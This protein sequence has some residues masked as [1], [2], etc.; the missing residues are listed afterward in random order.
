VFSALN[1]EL[2]HGV[3]LIL[4]ALLILQQVRF[5][6]ARHSAKKREELFQIITENADDM[7]ALVDMK[8]KRHY[9]S[10]SYKRILGYSPSELAETTSFEQIH[11]DDRLKVLDA[12]REARETGVGRR[13]Q[14]RMRHKNGTWRILESTASPIKSRTGEVEKLVIVNRDITDRKLA[15]ERLEHN[16]FHDALTGLPNHR[17]FVER[18]QHS[19]SHAQRDAKYK[20]A[21]LFLDV[22]GF[23]V[24]N[25][26]MGREVVDQVLVAVAQRLSECLADKDTTFRPEEGLAIGETV[27]AR[28]G[29]DDFPVLLQDIRDPSNAMQ[30]A[31]RLQ[32]AIAGPFTVNDQEV[33]V[34]ASIGI[35]LSNGRSGNPEDLLRDAEA[36]MRR[37]KT[38]GRGRCEIADPSVHS[39]AVQRLAL[40]NDLRNAIV[41]SEFG[42]HYQSIVQLKTR[43]IVGFEALLRWNRNGKVISAGEFIEVA[44]ETGLIVPIGLR[45]LQE[46]SQ[47]LKSWQSRFPATDPLQMTVKVSARQF[48][49]D[50]FV[51]ELAATVRENGLDPC[52]V[53]LEMTEGVTMLDLK[54]T[55]N[56]LWRVKRLGV[57][58]VVEHFGTGRMPIDCLRRFP[59]DG[60][61]LDRSLVSTMLSDPASKD[62]VRLI[63][64]VA[65]ELNLI[66]IA[67]GVE[68]PAQSMHLAELGCEFGQ[69]FLYSKAVEA[70]I[71]Q[72]MLQG[73]S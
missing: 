43:R 2:V 5:Y 18:L 62:I 31:Q 22:D 63:M 51:D 40:E 30:V 21:V 6:L 60:L 20:Y 42:V 56:V 8:R 67:E 48:T 57:R 15:E 24:L 70:R 65:R 59:F 25:D 53:Q 35:A 47:Q 17:W 55:A 64:H 33:R 7:I 26:V 1:P 71:A 27:L 3:V 39:R 34:S 41:R 66:V 68:N 13:L 36:A 54:L 9:N 69:G 23:K 11:S 29:A 28:S 52:S 46:A 61:K 50:G 44:E 73:R 16:S 37:A 38:H 12:A 58:V 45:L 4:A 72:Q 49:H 32:S 19:F 10:P 14:Y